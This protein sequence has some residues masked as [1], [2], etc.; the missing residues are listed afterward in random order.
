[1]REVNIEGKT[2]NIPDRWED[3]TL[4][5]YMK[6]AKLTDTDEEFKS[7]VIISAYTDIPLVDLKRLKLSTLHEIV[8]VMKFIHTPIPEQPCTE[9]SIG[10]GKEHQRF[11]VVQNVLE[12]EAQDYF[13]TEAILTE[14]KQDVFTALPKLLAV[15]CKKSGE[16]LDMINIEERET[17]FLD[18][19]NVVQA[20][21]IQVFFYG[22]GLTYNLNS[23]FYSNREMIL[24]AKRKECEDSLKR[25]DGTGWYGRWLKKTLARFLAYYMESWKKSSFGQV[26]EHKKS[27]STTI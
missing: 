7:L 5:Q 16:N 10:Y 9:F 25:L 18:H 8:E 26:S 14:A 21:G 3:V 19:M 17:L 27:N 22:L 2:V 15:V 20:M 11:Y 4:R 1:M 23:Q 6:I 24:E 13:A 12:A